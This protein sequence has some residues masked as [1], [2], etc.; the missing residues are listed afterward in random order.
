[1]AKNTTSSIPYKRLDP[2]NQE[3]RLLELSPA[4]SLDDKVK[5]RL[6]TV[7]FSDDLEFIAIS[8]LYGEQ[9]DPEV[10]FINGR[11]I[12]I[13]SHLAQALRH[14]RAVFFPSPDR[15]PRTRSGT[16]SEVNKNRRWLQQLMWHMSAALPAGAGQARAPLRIWLDLICVNQRDE[17]ETARQRGLTRQVYGAAQIVVGWLGLKG[18]HTD[19]AMAGFNLLDEHMP[20]NWGDPTDRALHPEN[21]A[22]GHEWVKKVVHTWDDG[23]GEGGPAARR[24]GMQHWLGYRDLMGRQYFQ[25]RWLLEEISAAQFPTFLIGDTIVPWTLLLRMARIMEEFKYSDSNVFPKVLPYPPP[26]Q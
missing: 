5:C 10:I 18:R 20:R 9:S 14:V 26:S 19:A 11:P 8:S 2:L 13:P 23:V 17:Q 15:R 16:S 3:I 6:R 21:Y 4:C 1:M 22:P 12:S 25:R 24:R 7:R